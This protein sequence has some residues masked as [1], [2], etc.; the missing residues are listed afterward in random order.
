[1]RPAAAK[2]AEDAHGEQERFV[3]QMILNEWGRIT[4][5][6]AELLE[7]SDSGSISRTPTALELARAL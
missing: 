2:L 4:K 5:E 1:L 3:A 7:L 6:L